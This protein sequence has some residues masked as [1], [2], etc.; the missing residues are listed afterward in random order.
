MS[1]LTT[2]LRREALGGGYRVRIRAWVKSGEEANAVRKDLLSLKKILV[3][4]DGD[5]SSF[6]ANSLTAELNRLNSVTITN[7][8]SQR[9]YEAFLQVVRRTHG[10]DGR[11]AEQSHEGDNPPFLM[12][13]IYLGYLLSAN[14]SYEL[15]G[16]SRNRIDIEYR[17]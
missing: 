12:K 17:Q 7:V 3:I 15:T 11:V 10:V 8:P 16:H 4:F 1:R 2:S 14:R 5:G 6:I 9:E 13:T